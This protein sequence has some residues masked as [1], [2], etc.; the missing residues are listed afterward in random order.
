LK[1]IPD[2]P[3]DSSPLAKN[4]HWELVQRVAASPQF[5]KATRLKDFLS[6]IT[7]RSLTNRVDEITEQQIG[8]HVFER[9]LAYNPA[10]DNIV[11]V[12]AR[13]LR[14]KLKDYFAGAGIHEPESIEI[15][16]G[17]YIPVFCPRPQTP[18]EARATA[19]TAPSVRPKSHGIWIAGGISAVLVVL[20]LWL[21]VENHALRSEAAP[22]WMK[23]ENL[24]GALLLNPDRRV[25]MV[26]DDSSLVILQRFAK[27]S[28]TVQQYAERNYLA[29]A[30]LPN[31][32]LRPLWEYLLTRPYTSIADL[33]LYSRIVAA[34]PRAIDR[35]SIRHAR[36]LQSRD[37][38]QGNFLIVGSPRSNPWTSLFNQQLN[39]RF[40]Y[41][42]G[43][44]RTSVVNVNPRPG[45]SPLYISQAA[46]E[47][48]GEGYALVSVTSNLGGN[49]VVLL[50]GGTSSEATEAAGEY[51]LDAGLTNELHRRFQ[52]NDL[53]K[54]QSFQL[55]L[56]TSAIGG[57]AQDATIVADRVQLYK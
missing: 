13:Y 26:V 16:K 31:P 34:N 10:E 52:V 35:I 4:P 27:G 44:S 56:R 57:T 30:P 21:A 18:P 1:G 7:E 39:F 24:V 20:C 23:T 54:I 53:R 22:G 25:C 9:D 48:S 36:S 41:Q 29:G 49:G 37:F 5:A 55:L 3:V 8:I 50:I 17:G 51:A 28:I 14:N 38:K 46:G 47:E 11:R 15:P 6:Y 45:E 2:T 43:Q 40:E 42:L 32:E 19:E 33:N 12:N